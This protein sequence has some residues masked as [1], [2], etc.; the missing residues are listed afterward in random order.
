LEALPN[1]PTRKGEPDKFSGDVW[2]DDVAIGEEPSRLR[3]SKV[4]FVPGAR[5]AWHS[6][7]LGQTLHVIEGAGLVQSGGAGRVPSRDG[8][9][10]EIHSGYSVYTVPREWHWHGAAPDHYMAHLTITETHAEDPEPVWADHVTDDEYGRALL[11]RFS[12]DPW[13]APAVTGIAI[14]ER[15]TRGA[16]AREI[17]IT[18]FPSQPLATGVRFKLLTNA[19]DPSAVKWDSSDFETASVDDRGEVAAK[20]PGV[21]SITARLNNSSD[22]VSV[23]IT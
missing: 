19:A 7:P 15:V 4:R 14:A 23:T 21:V 3:V 5:T 8:E 10:I 1:K 2:I 16:P 12:K 18:R 11:A 22:V 9:V 20:Q 13:M 17:E 6:H